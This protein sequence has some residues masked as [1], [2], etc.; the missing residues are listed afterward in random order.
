MLGI[1]KEHTENNRKSY[2]EASEPKR[3]FNTGLAHLA[4]RPPYINII[5]RIQLDMMNS[6]I[7]L[8]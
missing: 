4:R 3:V 8:S 5:L 6:I 7:K 2:I 1:M